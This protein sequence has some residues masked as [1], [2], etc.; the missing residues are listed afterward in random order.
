M[1]DPTTTKL[2]AVGQD[3]SRFTSIIKTS[4][5][6]MYNAMCAVDKSTGKL[7]FM[8]DLKNLVPV[9]YLDK[10]ADSGSPGTST[11]LTGD[12]TMKATA[13]SGITIT[14]ATNERVS[15]TGAAS[16]ANTFD[17]V[18]M[19]DGSTFTLTPP[20]CAVPVGV[21][22]RWISS[23]YCEILI[24]PWW[25]HFVTSRLSIKGTKSWV[26]NLTVMSGTAEIAVVSF[27]AQEHFTITDIWA[28]PAGVDTGTVAGAQ[29]LHV[30]VGGVA[31]TGGVLT[32]GYASFDASGDVDT[33][34]ASA[35]VITAGG[36]V[37]IGDTVEIVMAASGTGFT[38]N[39]VAA[40]ELV[41][42]VTYI[43]FG[44]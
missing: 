33:K 23:T 7:E 37:H 5:P 36:E 24:F 6:L 40:A 25:F 28:K 32:L 11:D 4:E 19:S 15:V 34:V 43:P 41:M 27:V 18:Y 22:K 12:G 14:D 39:K 10:R 20:T 13:V 17:P 38:A 35:G 8:D 21:V 31:V 16:A 1:A 26:R 42:E 29:L 9:G 2:Y 3:L 44:A 30:E